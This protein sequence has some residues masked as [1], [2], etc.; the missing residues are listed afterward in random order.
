MATPAYL[1]QV[2]ETNPDGLVDAFTTML[3]EFGYTSL[4]PDD[5][6]SAIEGYYAGTTRKENVIAMMVA[7]YLEKGT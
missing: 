6:R 7:D 1:K 4:S 5:V 3:R 2:W